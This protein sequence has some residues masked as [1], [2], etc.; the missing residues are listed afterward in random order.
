MSLVTVKN[1]YQVVIPERVRADIGVHVGD[2][3]D[4]KAERGKITFTPKSVVILDREL[5]LG[6]E[7]ARKGRTYGPFNT[8]EEMIVSMQAQL[9][10]RKAGTHKTKRLR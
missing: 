8:A 4:V 10:K 9:K 1:K 7:D 2:T 3:F 6:L 5:A